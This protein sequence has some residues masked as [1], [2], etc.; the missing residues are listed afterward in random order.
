MMLSLLRTMDRTDAI[1]VFEQM[2]E[3]PHFYAR[4]QTM[5]E[6]LA[7]DPERALPHLRKMSVSDRHPDVRAAARATLAMLLADAACLEAEMCPA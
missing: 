1:P 7:L 3:S 4:W 2:L 6:F 5:R